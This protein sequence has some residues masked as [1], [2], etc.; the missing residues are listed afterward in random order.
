[1]VIYKKVPFDNGSNHF[2]IDEPDECP[3]CKHSIQPVELLLNGY[4]D[5]ISRR[6]IVAAY[7]CKHC[8]RPF[9]VHF[10]INDS[11]A[12]RTFVAPDRFATR[13]F[14]EH[15]SSVSPA[16]VKIYNEALAAESSGLN[17]VSGIGYRKALEF[18]IKDFLIHKNSD[19]KEKIENMQ[20]AN[21]IANKVTNENLKAVA[22]RSTWL[23]NDQT[24]Y[25]QKFAEFDVADMKKFI[26]ATV[27]WISMELI[28]A[29]AL[30]I[31]PRGR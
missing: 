29:E 3:I 12:V 7:L 18:L 21:C 22:S 4:R 26:D 16:F 13:H 5:N 24:H 27:Y 19:D 30:A 15:I 2:N 14:D 8:Y 10:N 31:E 23:G 20:L 25:V 11:T 1:M 9:I 17:E 28:T 6:H